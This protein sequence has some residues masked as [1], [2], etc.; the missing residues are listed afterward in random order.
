M[1]QERV[2]IGTTNFGT[3]EI[4]LS[5]S[6]NARTQ[7]RASEEKT[8]KRSMRIKMKKISVLRQKSSVSVRARITT[9]LNNLFVLVYVHCSHIILAKNVFVKYSILQDSNCYKNIELVTLNFSYRNM[10]LSYQNVRAKQATHKS[11]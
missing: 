2:E 8:R 1:V 11:Y 6:G 4:G 7:T 5:D 9:M 10:K 3:P